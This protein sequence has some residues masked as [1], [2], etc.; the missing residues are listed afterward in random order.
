[1]R[2]VE[3][4]EASPVTDRRNAQEMLREWLRILRFLSRSLGY[5]EVTVAALPQTAQQRAEAARRREKRFR[6]RAKDKRDRGERLLAFLFE[7]SAD[8]QA[9]NAGIAEELILDEHATRIKRP[10]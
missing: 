7:R 4:N 1:M 6:D 3:A 8:A 9:A 2:T 5:E 10:R